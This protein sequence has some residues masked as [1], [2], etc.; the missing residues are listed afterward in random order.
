MNTK[1]RPLKK[2]VFMSEVGGFDVNDDPVPMKVKKELWKLLP[3]SMDWEAK[4]HFLY[5][6]GQ[7][8]H[9]I[10]CKGKAAPPARVIAELESLQTDARKLLRRLASLSPLGQVSISHQRSTLN[11]GNPLQPAVDHPDSEAPLKT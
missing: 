5:L 10:F 6:A 4:T 9:F 1:L 11:D 7:N 8:A 2:P 3:S